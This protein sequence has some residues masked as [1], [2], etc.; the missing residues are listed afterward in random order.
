M[1]G[2]WVRY[3]NAYVLDGPSLLGDLRIILTTMRKVLTGKIN[4]R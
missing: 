3:D 4:G 2:D 1:F